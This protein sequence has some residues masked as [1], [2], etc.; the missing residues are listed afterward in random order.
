MNYYMIIYKAKNRKRIPLK[1]GLNGGGKIGYCL[2]IG[3][4]VVFSNQKKA[5]EAINQFDHPEDYSIET[6]TSNH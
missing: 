3:K 1:Y 2:H 4:I 6:L 5:Q